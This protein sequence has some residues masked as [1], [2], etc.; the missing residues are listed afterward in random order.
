MATFRYFTDINNTQIEVTYWGGMD[1]AK[2]AAMFPGI[3]GKKF[4]S[5]ARIVGKDAA[6]NFQPI[7]RSI[8]RKSNPSN[9]KCDARCLNATGFLC[10]CSCGGKNHGAGNFVCEAA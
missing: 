4:D 5:F 2:F 7:T 10:E 6:G 8:Q 3:K 9:H 1:N